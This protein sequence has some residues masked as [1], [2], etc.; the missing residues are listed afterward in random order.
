M[1]IEK[2]QQY[3]RDTK[4][5]EDRIREMKKSADYIRW[6]DLRKSIDNLRRQMEHFEDDLGELNWN[7]NSLEEKMLK[8]YNIKI[9]T[10]Y[11]LFRS[12]RYD[13]IC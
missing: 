11:G 6:L 12:R 5:E 3:L 8:E 13:N 9:Y 1:S 7:R 4:A 10:K 2:R